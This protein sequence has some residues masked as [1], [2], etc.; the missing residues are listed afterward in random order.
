VGNSTGGLATVAASGMA[1][2]DGIVGAVNF[3]GGAGGGVLGAG[4]PCNEPEVRRI[5]VEAAR[6][7]HLPMLWLYARDDEFWGAE[8]P[9]EWLADYL[10]GGGEATLHEA[11]RGGHDVVSYPEEW[12]A[13]LD[14]YL[15]ALGF[16]K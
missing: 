5:F 16:R 3:A 11:N 1:L 8:L 13:A 6:T 15:A 12:N 9:K 14:T 7:A 4:K 10:N 2:P